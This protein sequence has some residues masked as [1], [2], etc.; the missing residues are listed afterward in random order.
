ME[1][2]P[3]TEL[4]REMKSTPRPTRI[5]SSSRSTTT[6]AGCFRFSEPRATGAA[7]SPAAGSP[8]TI[9][10]PPYGRVYI[11][12]L[13]H[14]TPA[15][16]SAAASSLL[17]AGPRRKYR[18]GRPGGRGGGREPRAGVCASAGSRSARCVTSAR[19]R[20]ASVRESRRAHLRSRPDA[21]R[22]RSWC[23]CSTRR[24]IASRPHSNRCASFGRRFGTN[25]AR[26]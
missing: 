21:M 8:W 14:R 13:V 1:S 9:D 3:E 4:L 12:D 16:R 5:S 7:R 23:G 26:R 11:A 20:G 24:S 25:S 10:L 19:P 17:G 6:K 22:W 18:Q 15:S 2:M